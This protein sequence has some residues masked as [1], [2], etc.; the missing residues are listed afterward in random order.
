MCDV[1]NVSDVCVS[2]VNNIRAEGVKALSQ[3]LTY[4]TQLTHLDLSRECVIIDV[5]LGLRDV[6]CEMCCEYREQD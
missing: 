3:C 1:C 6:M 2:T 4:L 5:L